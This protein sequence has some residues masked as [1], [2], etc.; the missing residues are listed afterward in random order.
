MVVIVCLS[1]AALLLWDLDD[2]L[3]GN[4]NSALCQKTP[5]HNCQLLV[6]ALKLKDTWLMWQY[7]SSC[8]CPTQN[9]D[10][11][12]IM[13]LWYDRWKTLQCGWITNNSEKKGWP[14]VLHRDIIDSLSVIANAL[15][16]TAKRGTTIY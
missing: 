14:K 3:D 4:V 9:L 11:N 5:K 13:M 10:L 6:H 8:Q 16:I 15:L 12:L 1:G 7:K 2:I